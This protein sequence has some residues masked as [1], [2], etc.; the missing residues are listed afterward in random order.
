MLRA[1]VLPSGTARYR[2]PYR[3]G[4]LTKCSEFLNQLLNMIISVSCQINRF[5]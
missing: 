2:L 4:L 5:A 3:G 1:L